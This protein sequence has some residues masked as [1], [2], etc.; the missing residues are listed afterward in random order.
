VW[1]PEGG[2]D[3]VPVGGVGCVGGHRYSAGRGS[4]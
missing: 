3:E 2:G 1:F 4:R